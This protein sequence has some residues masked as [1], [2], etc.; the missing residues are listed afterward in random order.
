MVCVGMPKLSMPTFQNTY[1]I[2]CVAYALFYVSMTMDIIRGHVKY[3]YN[4]HRFAHA[5]AKYR[6]IIHMVSYVYHTGAWRCVIYIDMITVGMP[7]IIY[8]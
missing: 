5:N 3:T 1:N 4:I 8:V 6:H 7:I 2:H